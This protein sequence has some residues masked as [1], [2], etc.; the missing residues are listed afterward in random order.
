M[1]VLLGVIDPIAISVGPFQ[2]YW[3]GIIIA[4]AMFVAISLATREAK[5]EGLK[6]IQLLI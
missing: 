2:I 1:N 4:V 5:K 3:Y 6:R